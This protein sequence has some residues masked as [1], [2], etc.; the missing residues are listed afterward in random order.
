LVFGPVTDPGPSSSVS[1]R[2]EQ[3]AFVA[4]EPELDEEFPVRW[5]GPDALTQRTIYPESL[6]E[7]L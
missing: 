1:G 4:C 2:D 6:P 7:L 5:L 3:D